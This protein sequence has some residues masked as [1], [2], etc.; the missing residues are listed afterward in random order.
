[1]LVDI[2][3]HAGGAIVSPSSDQRIRN[4]ECFVNLFIDV[5]STH[6]RAAATISVIKGAGGI[7]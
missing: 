6:R 1:M 7:L 4:D 3:G 2:L 5:E